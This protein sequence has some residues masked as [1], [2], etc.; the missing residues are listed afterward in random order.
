MNAAEVSLHHWKN[1]QLA[2]TVP[3]LATVGKKFQLAITVP[4][5]ATVLPLHIMTFNV[6]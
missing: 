6:L 1:L 5:L 3:R 4:R 2:I